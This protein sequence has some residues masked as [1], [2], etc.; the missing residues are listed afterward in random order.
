MGVPSG[1]PGSAKNPTKLRRSHLLPLEEKTPWR[2]FLGEAQAQTG[3]APLLSPG[4]L[5]GSLWSHWHSRGLP[6][7]WGMS[8]QRPC[9]SE[10]LGKGKCS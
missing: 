8:R 5:V 10:R 4:D 6:G 2:G 1:A 7:M 9:P 3:A